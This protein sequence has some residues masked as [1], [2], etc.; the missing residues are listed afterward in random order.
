M[1]DTTSDLKWR[2]GQDRRGLAYDQAAVL[3]HDVHTKWITTLTQHKHR[4]PPPDYK[5]VTWQQ[6]HNADCELFMLAAQAARSGIRPDISGEKPLD[7]IFEQLMTDSRVTFFL[8]PYQMGSV[9]ARDLPN[10]VGGQP[11]QKQ[12]KVNHKQQQPN[13]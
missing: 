3:S 8:M 7:R 4:V 2:L 10:E 12:Q 1:A 5:P 13:R 11:R 9:H 6:I